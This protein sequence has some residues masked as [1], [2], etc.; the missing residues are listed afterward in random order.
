MQQLSS[1]SSKRLV[2]KHKSVIFVA[3]SRFLERQIKGIY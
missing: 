2:K 3:S 1:V